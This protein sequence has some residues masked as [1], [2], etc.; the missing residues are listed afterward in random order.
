M[1]L[2]HKLVKLLKLVILGVKLKESTPTN[3]I[4]IPRVF[5]V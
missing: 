4:I 1:G 5:S 3:L 2:R